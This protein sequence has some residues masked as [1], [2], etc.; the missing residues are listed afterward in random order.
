MRAF[1]MLAGWALFAPPALARE[2]AAHGP[3][4]RAADLY[5]RADRLRVEH[6]D[7]APALQVY[8]EIVRRFWESPYSDA[9]RL[10]V[11]RCLL[12]LGQVDEAEQHLKAFYE[13]DPD[14][15]YRGESLLA[16]GRIAL[17][18]RLNLSGARTCFE[19]LEAWLAK[20]RKAVGGDALRPPPHAE[21]PRVKPGQLVNRE[22]CW[23]YLHRL[24]ERCA[25]YLG[26]VRF[27]VGDH[28]AAES[29]YKRIK[30]IPPL[31][32]KVDDPTDPDRNGAW[33]NYTH[34]EDGAERGY[35]YA[36]PQELALYKKR[37]RQRLA[38]LLFD[39]YY[40]MCQWDR[41]ERMARRL[42][43]GEFGPLEG[44]HREYPQYAYA[45]ALIETQGRKAAFHQYMKLVPAHNGRAATWTQSRAALAAAN[46]THTSSDEDLRRKSRQLYRRLIKAEEQNRFTYQARIELARDLVEFDGRREEGYELLRTFPKESRL[47]PLAEFLLKRYLQIDRQKGHEGGEK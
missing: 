7:F 24:T 22:T 20:A 32:R 6:K 35:L 30:R 17:E 16:L 23:W 18:H 26:F 31:A 34:L 11:G 9:S 15:L 45:T 47:R 37:P 44:R 19:G 25:V 2:P 4:N 33:N 29:T 12:A 42:L 3:Q 43:K 13:A 27:A 41:G 5:C 46:I 39:F 36:Y 8:R 1:L 10:N 14:G 38:V 40:F 21:R 28:Q